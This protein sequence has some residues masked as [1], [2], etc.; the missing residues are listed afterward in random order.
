MCTDSQTVFNFSSSSFSSYFSSSS[1]PPTLPSFFYACNRV[2][3]TLIDFFLL[4]RVA[5]FLLSRND[6]KV[7]FSVIL[8]DFE[9]HLGW[10]LINHHTLEMKVQ[11]V[12]FF[13]IYKN[14]NLRFGI[15]YGEMFILKFL[16]GGTLF[17]KVISGLIFSLAWTKELSTP[18]ASYYL[19]SS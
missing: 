16:T 8:P 18:D 17:C 1:P 3:F 4:L 7:N 12:F 14:V 11:F 13:Y 2:S 19:F 9:Y 5:D 10:S 15:L 6:E